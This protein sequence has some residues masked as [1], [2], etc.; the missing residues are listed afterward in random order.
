MKNTR[1][2][3]LRITVNTEEDA[4]KLMKHPRL[5]HYHIEDQKRKNPQLIMYDV[6][7]TIEIK[8]LKD[9]I[10]SQNLEPED[11]S[12]ITDLRRVQKKKQPCT[13][14]SRPAHV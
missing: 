10:L 9:I 4:V 3:S 12:E 7:S 11:E 14:L 6:D 8:Q 2:N 5:E 1:A 13:G